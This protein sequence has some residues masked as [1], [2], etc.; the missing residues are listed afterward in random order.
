VVTKIEVLGFNAPAEHYQ[1]LKDFLSDATLFGLMPVLRYAKIIKLNF[2]MLLL[3]LRL[4]LMATLLLLPTK[5]I[6]QILKG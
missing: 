1:L 4:L 3:P 5:K 2:Q 6:L